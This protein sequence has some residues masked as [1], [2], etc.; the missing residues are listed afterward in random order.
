MEKK[1]TAW[2]TTG[3]NQ[4]MSVS[5]FNPQF[6]FE[7]RNL[8]LSTNEGN[9]LMSWVNE[10]G[11]L[12]L[13]DTDGNNIQLSGIPIG[14]AVIN[15]QL[16][17]F[18][19]GDYIYKLTYSP[20][21]NTKMLVEELFHGNLSFSTDNPLETLVSYESNEVQ[22]VY[23]TDG[24]NQPRVINIAGDI[25]EDNNTQ[26]DFVPA[27]QLGEGA[28]VTRLDSGGTFAEGVIQYCITYFN[29]YGQQSNIAWVSPLCY[30]SPVDRGA[31]PDEIVNCSFKIFME[32]LDS[33]FDYARIYSIQRT[34]INS[35]PIVKLL[36]DVVITAD[37]SV[38]FIDDGERGSTVDPTELLFIGGREITALTMADKD[39]TL[40]LG[41]IT[42]KTDSLKPLQDFFD[43][44]RGKEEYKYIE[45]SR[46]KHLSFEVGNGVY[47]YKNQLRGNNRN[48]TTF[49][50]G[51]WYRFGFQLQKIT[52][53]WSE[54]VFISDAQNTLYPSETS[55]VGEV[56]VAE[57]KAEI[58]LSSVNNIDYSKYKKIRPVIVYPEIGDRTV[59]CQGVL[60][61]TVFNSTD[62]KNKTT[63]AQASWFFRPYYNPIDYAS[64]EKNEI[65]G[66][67]TFSGEEEME[68][69]EGIF[70]S[71]MKGT[72]KAGINIDEVLE[73][74]YLTLERATNEGEDNNGEGT[75]G[76]GNGST[77]TEDP[78]RSR[79]TD[80]SEGQDPDPLYE[81]TFYGVVPTGH[82]REYLF[83]TT[84]LWLDGNYKDLSFH[85]IFEADKVSKLSD[86]ISSKYG[87][88]YY[89][90]P[91][92]EAPES[93]DGFC[94]KD[95]DIIQKITFDSIFSNRNIVSESTGNQIASTHYESIF[96]EKKNSFYNDWKKVEIQ[97]SIQQ[98]GTPFGSESST[99]DVTN[100]EF[101]VDQSIVTFNSP[102]IDFDT[103]MQSFNLGDTKLRIVGIIPITSYASAH[104]IV[105]TNM[106]DT[107]HN[108]SG[109]SLAHVFGKGEI[110]Y[111]V[112]NNNVCIC[113]GRRLL[114]EYL[115]NDIH[116]TDDGATATDADKVKTDNYTTNYM[117]FPWQKTGSLNNDTR[118][119]P[120]ASSW[121]QNKVMS[122]I[123]FSMGSMYLS[124]FK[125][126]PNL[127][128]EIFLTE[129]A[130]IQNIRLPKQL[131]T[132]SD[133][134]YY[135]NVDKVLYNSKGYYSRQAFK[136]TTTSVSMKYLSTSHAVLAFHK[137]S[138][139][140][141][142]PILPY[143]KF[144]SGAITYKPGYY[145][146]SRLSRDTT[147][148]TFWGDT[149]MQ[150]D[151]KEVDLDNLFVGSG[152]TPYD[153][154]WL[155]ELYRDV[156]PSTRFG[157]D[158]RQAILANNWV[159]A[160]DAKDITFRDSTVID[161][162]IKW[163]EGDTYYQR[164]D[165]LKTYP[166][167][168]DDINQMVEILS[169][170]CE[171]HVNIDGRY[172]RNRGLLDNT[173][174][175][176]ANF[177]LMNLVYSQRN[178]FFTYKKTDEE[179]TPRVY[180]NYITF[181]KTK[182]SGAEVDLWTNIT[183]ANTLEMDGDKGSISALERL[184]N[185][186]ICF[187]D[188]GIS[189]ILY[190]ENVQLST[191]EGVP[192][193]IANSGKVQGKRYLSNSVGCSNKWSVV[194]TPS[195]IYFVDSNNKAI[196]VFNGQLQN[197]SGSKGF[198]TW[199]K[200]NIPSSKVLWTPDDFNNFVGM[201]D[202]LN[203]DVLFINKAEALAYS[204]RLEA[205]TSFYDYGDTPYL[206]N[207]DDSAIWIRKNSSNSTLWKHNAGNYSS[208]FDKAKPYGTTLI[209]NAEPQLDKMFTNLEFRACVE[210]EGTSKT[211]DSEK[212]LDKFYLPFNLLEVWDEYQ[213]GYT[214]L[215]NRN[216]HSAM[217]HST[218]Q[219]EASLKR[220]FRI[221]RCDIPRDNAPIDDVKPSGY[222]GSTDK[223]LGISRFVK[224]PNDRMRNP[225]LYLKLWRNP[226]E[227]VTALPKVEIHDIVMSYFI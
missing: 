44:R 33:N 96:S 219:W 150:F 31:R 55:S 78:S 127:N 40:F 130:F 139:A 47:H 99:S 131:D 97:G 21:D 76:G 186:L 134:N 172:D 42:E 165:C 190:N 94:Y 176:P 185:Q 72:F 1:F 11:T 13:K 7:N 98:Y 142:I 113:G 177:N 34:S 138:E 129:N 182:T 14:T 210:G 225:W 2:K 28:S 141:Q 157:G 10:K 203:Q 3:M 37:S 88:L 149:G 155:G 54:P 145:D 194:N 18:T 167:T 79:S 51:E 92:Q 71:V 105:A 5:A 162:T 30:I 100:T 226:E 53:E 154:L 108:R 224:R 86:A 75:S 135:P 227:G 123:L 29:K 192:V 106:L 187:Q 158:G 91:D 69:I 12:Q 159:V 211:V 95:G 144:T 107:N 20:V 200:N 15:H 83:F 121:L 57:A 136:E 70:V 46:D 147:F 85:T 19:K 198:N 38:T 168:K 209:G 4:D 122:H 48:I 111:N 110:D 101:F 6:A 193:E 73:R 163:T 161:P 222:I 223:Q 204:E 23:W 77:E 180:P 24:R 184:D 215:D 197:L 93:I 112:I 214:K 221:W 171:T 89:N 102:D 169:F 152:K 81:G 80:V 153:F 188:S 32:A 9:T 52:G 218:K 35:T 56:T 140:S 27:L 217:Q 58:P 64:N 22:K 114:A 103:K 26:F 67:Y 68:T 213:H 201:Y 175:N 41:N 8:R 137:A 118:P 82:D 119:Q 109:S 160:G 156:P 43:E 216:G 120:D 220:K 84:G 212:M 133:I 178:N 74:G 189:Q 179:G 87:Y 115:W 25:Q 39:G 166:F 183:L 151:Q 62:R 90:I 170:P 205:F 173:T 63:F 49:K 164:Y 104:H 208:F 59:L 45:F 17:V 126:Y 195:G 50:G 206:C 36:E 65:R 146:Y 125:D 199:A 128:A 191:V 132:S 148:T 66:S 60:N 143:G 174:V 16:I 124:D 181:T 61:P 202:R 116:V 117:V 207:L 196:Y